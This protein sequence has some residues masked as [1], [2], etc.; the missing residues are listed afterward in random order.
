MVFIQSPVTNKKLLVNV[1]VA[2]DLGS[3][4]APSPGW[5]LHQNSK[6]TKLCKS[7]DCPFDLASNI[8]KHKW[9]DYFEMG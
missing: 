9:M 8:L 1:F 5:P 2:T 7:L 3:Q 6:I 4:I